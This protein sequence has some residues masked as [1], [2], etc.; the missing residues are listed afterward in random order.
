MITS[1]IARSTWRIAGDLAFR[2]MTGNRDYT[3]AQHRMGLNSGPYLLE[4]PGDLTGIH[5][6]PVRWLIEY[7][8]TLWKWTGEV[9]A[10]PNLDLTGDGIPDIRVD[11]D[12]VI[13][14]L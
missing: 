11:G 8:L 6:T 5:F 10:P 4:A 13:I 9:S 3:A 12:S 14:P 1:E 7:N 2:S